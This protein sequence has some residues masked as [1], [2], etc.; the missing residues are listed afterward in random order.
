M[1]TE[2]SPLGICL[3][4]SR[5][6]RYMK[7]AAKR[8]VPVVAAIYFFPAAFAVYAALALI[9]FAR[10]TRRTLDALDRYFVGNGLGTC[11]L[12]PVNLLLDVLTLP[13]RNRGIYRLDDLPVAYADEIL[14]LIE[15]AHKSDLV[16]KLE[17]K[18]EG[19][20]R[21]MIFFKWYGRNVATSVDVPAFHRQYRYIRTI[22]VSIF[23]SGQ[24]TGKHF[25][26]LRVTLRVLYNVNDI[27]SDRAY[28]QVGR[29]THHWRTDKLLIFDDTLQHQ[30]VNQTDEVRYCLFVD[31]LRPS[32]APRLLSAILAGVRA[33][34]ARFN[35]VFYKHW[36]FIK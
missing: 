28:V 13:Y 21:G 8:V 2:L 9:D 27:H 17:A 29:H 10:N 14:G 18:M 31:I 16:G 24:S 3:W 11:L 32:L 5:A 35:F 25:G 6:S 34:I 26:P 36:V 4:P 22:G 30:S 15:A 33:V 7:R 20:K 1:T 23:N 19:K 12:A